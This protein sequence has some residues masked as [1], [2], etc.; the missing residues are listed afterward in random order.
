M[1]EAAS[2]PSSDVVRCGVILENTSQA[3]GRDATLTNIPLMQLAP[4]LPGLVQ[5]IR[6]PSN[7]RI[8]QRIFLHGVAVSV[9]MSWF[10]TAP[11]F[12]GQLIP[13]G[14]RKDNSSFPA[15]TK[16]TPR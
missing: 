10:S 12:V 15:R 1:G 8:G 11:A 5:K 13:A 16:A 14:Q 6:P 2:L 4:E 7:L 3:H 9:P